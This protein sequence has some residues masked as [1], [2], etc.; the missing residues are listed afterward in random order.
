VVMDATAIVDGLKRE[1]PEADYE[2]APATDQPTIF[3]PREL[4]VETCRVLRDSPDLRFSALSDVTAV[5]WWPAEPRFVVVYHL[6]S[7]DF[8]TRLRLKVRLGGADPHVA[9]VCRLWPAAN[10]AEREVWDLFGIVFD[11]HP[12]LR[13]L[14]MPRDWEGHPLRKDYPVQIH[15]PV[16]IEKA[17]GRSEEEFQARIQEDREEWVREEAGPERHRDDT[18]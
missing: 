17:L 1:L 16:K 18:R 11:G 13:R 12:D 9:T 6:F 8:A 2:V 4:I 15:K 10:W 14:L 5:D 7:I 3:V